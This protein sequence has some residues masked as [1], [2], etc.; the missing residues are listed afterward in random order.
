LVL[1]DRNGRL[2]HRDAPTQATLKAMDERSLDVG[3]SLAEP[4]V[5]TNGVGTSL[6]T[7]RPTLVVGQ[8]HYME[9]FQAFTCANA[10]IIQPI[11][12]RVEGTVG[13]VCPAEETGPLLL[14]TAVQLATQ[15]SELL[16]ERASPK[17]RF[18]LEH[19]LRRRRSPRNAVATMGDGVL[20]ATPAAQ[21][22]LAGVDQRELWQRIEAGTRRG[23]TMETQLQ[24]PTQPPLHL[25]CLPLHRG[26]DFEGV[27]IEFN[28]EPL[29]PSASGRAKVQERLGDLVGHSDPWQAT[30]REA[31]QAAQLDAPVIIIGERGTGRLSV[32]E[33]MAR[34]GGGGFTVL[35]GADVLV[36]GPRSWLQRAK[37][38]LSKDG[39]VLFRR[40]DQLD[41]NSAAALASLIA[42]PHQARTAATAQETAVAA[43]GLSSLLDQ[44]NVLR[45]DLPPLR[46]RRD[47]IPH[48]TRHFARLL[49]HADVDQRVIDVL[50]RQT[51]PGNLTEL[52]QTLRSA[53]AKAKTDPIGLQHLPRQVRREHSR[54]PLHGLR[55][56]EA[57]AI[58]A[59]IN[60]T[61]TR[62]E[63][64]KQLGISRATLF[65][66]INAYGL[67]LDL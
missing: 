44:L 59:A 1:A 28:S 41:D 32:A 2:T 53:S 63:A 40:I 25:R 5:G 36:D 66:R 29:K 12:G 55:Q 49:G 7:R 67:D 50:Y 11:T 15:I 24:R 51:W 47:D 9:A 23:G 14:P 46:N 27:A 30:V 39:T 52:R 45:I 6:E 3:F 38:A 26:G 10:P 21:Q 13:V 19:F 42:R 22:I 20:I 65:R 43:P 56:H 54:K 4:D 57:D 37:T 62:A 17:E 34:H 60:S 61:S 58:V 48:L 35:E 64:A 16:L 33:A 31:L 8:D 18:L